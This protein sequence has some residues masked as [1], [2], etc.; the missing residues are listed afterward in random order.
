MI[1]PFGSFRPEVRRALPLLIGFRLVSNAAFRYGFSF[2]PAIAAGTGLSVESLG[3]LLSAR[4]LAALA[5]P[6]LGRRSDRTS[7]TRMMTVTSAIVVGGLVTAALGPV[8]LIIGFIVIG[9]GKLGYDVAMN[10][11]VGEV[12]AYERRGK[13]TGLVELSWAG[14]A[15]LL[16]PVI[17][18]LID[19]VGWWSASLFLAVLAAPLS[20]ALSRQPQPKASPTSIGS[21]FPRRGL[22]LSPSVLS[23][24]GAFALM[25]VSSQFLIVGHG[26]WLADT[27]QFDAT[28]I[29]FA[30]FAIGVIEAIGS[31]ASSRFTDL[32]GKRNSMAMGM[33][34]L[35]L[36][37]AGM[38]R[39]ADPPLVAGLAM[40]ITAFLGFEFGVVSA[41]PLLS[42]L[43][44]DARAQMM[45]LALGGSTVVRA[46]CSLLGVWLYVN[47]GISWLAGAGAVAGLISVGVLMTAVTEPTAS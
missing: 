37:L 2:L 45:G 30:I 14:A 34:L 29:G 26:V 36:A 10:S 18:V 22:T 6:A 19:R 32:L 25:S 42:E 27:Y 11:W 7:T 38:S 13:A 21:E 16:L 39:F 4:D 8:G 31:L 5:G 17:G 41:I 43:D 15:L 40:L 3:R 35:A 20:I 46:I 47:H 1:A 23:T 24:L 33:A 44:P 9:F 12:V 28:R